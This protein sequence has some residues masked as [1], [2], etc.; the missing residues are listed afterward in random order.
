M[1]DSNSIPRPYF[2]ISVLA[3]K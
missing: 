2:L 1:L 3:L